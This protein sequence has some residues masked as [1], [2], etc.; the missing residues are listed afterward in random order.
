M[1]QTRSAL[2][3]LGLGV[4]FGSSFLFMKVLVA[5]IGPLTMVTG[6]LILGASAVLIVLGIRRQALG[7][8]PLLAA[9]VAL[10]A[11]L[12]LVVPFGLVSW[13]EQYINSGV[14]AALISTMPLFTALFA[15]GIFADERLTAG[16]LAGL[17]AGFAGVVVLTGGN[18]DLTD[19]SVIGQFAVVGAAASY[20]AGAVYSRALLKSQDPLS[21]GGL[22]L[23]MGALLAAP[24]ALAFDG[25]P[26]FALSVKAW[27][28]LLAL[29][30][31][32]T[33]AAFVGY[34][35]LVD[36]GGSVTASLVTYIVPVVGLALG[37]AVL[38]E[39]IGLNAVAGVLLIILG[40]VSAMIAK[41]PEPEAQTVPAPAAT[42]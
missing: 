36:N 18:F 21:L 16:R 41:A 20:A 15:A 12:S 29:G 7:W 37:W 26:T 30:L 42:E 33:G 19:S 35:W 23:V 3:L 24:L 40:V 14:A 13:A 22:E 9:K 28:A 8:T 31:A 2:V 11:T 34:L 10:L 32:G 6:R 39:R 17:V 27:G 4:V 38:D 1:I 5:E 25:A